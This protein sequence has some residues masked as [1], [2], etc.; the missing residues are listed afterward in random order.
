[1]RFGELIS[2]AI[3][4]RE[5]HIIE[6][7]SLEI[8]T[9]GRIADAIMNSSFISSKSNKY[10]NIIASKGR[11]H[12]LMRTPKLKSDRKKN[13]HLYKDEEEKSEDEKNDVKILKDEIKKLNEQLNDKQKEIRKSEKYG[14]LLSDLF[15]KGII[16]NEGN[17]IEEKN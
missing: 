12:L 1:M 15:Q 11:S 8:K 17:F 2:D 13:M 7:N 10:I 5:R 9:E 6:S 3:K 4:S 16:D 14:D